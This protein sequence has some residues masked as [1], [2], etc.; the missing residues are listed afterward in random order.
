M[1]VLITGAAGQVGQAIIPHLTEHELILGDIAYCPGYDTRWRYLDVTDR[2]EVID[3]VADCDAVVHLAMM[4][5]TL[6]VWDERSW[7]LAQ[8]RL[9]VD[10]VGTYNVLRAAGEA[11]KQ[12]VYLSSG[13]AFFGYGLDETVTGDMPVKGGATYGLIKL[14]GEGLC[15]VIHEDFGVPVAVIRSGAAQPAS[16]TCDKEY[17]DLFPA[18]HWVSVGENLISAVRQAL[19]HPEHGHTVTF[20]VGDNPGRTWDI[21]TAWL[22][23]RWSPRYS[24][25]A[26]GW[27]REDAWELG[28]EVDCALVDAAILGDVSL[29][30][31]CGGNPTAMNSLALRW[32]CRLGH[33]ERTDWL[34]ERGADVNA[35]GGDPL[36]KAAAG[37]HTNLVNL[38]IARGADP[39]V[40]EGEALAWAVAGGHHETAQFLLD[41]DFVSPTQKAVALYW[42]VYRD[43]LPMMEDLLAAGADPDYGFGQILR[44]A[45]YSRHMDLSGNPAAA[46]MLLRAGANVNFLRGGCSH[47]TPLLG[48]A[49]HCPPYSP[50]WVRFLLDHGADPA[51]VDPIYIRV[52]VRYGWTDMLAM[53]GLDAKGEPLETPVP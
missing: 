38:L 9:P 17:H 45:V 46:E 6:A 19:V 35:L 34:I 20:C 52:A 12:V 28:T 4:G 11:G 14:W 32:S 44:I 33:V 50:H 25:Q 53:L 22:L 29:L 1:R 21:E 16:G 42:A 26:S 30:V 47:S 43:D 37:G 39:E 49:I 8:R 24:I 40:D 31:E 10:L 18:F 7:H 23:H 27:L 15:R 2:R 36:R 5:G 3:A 41:C 51:L 48:E 13:N